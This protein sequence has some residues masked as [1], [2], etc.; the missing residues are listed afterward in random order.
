MCHDC[1]RAKK[2]EKLPVVNI[3]PAVND[4][5]PRNNNSRQGCASVTGNYY[6]NCVCMRKL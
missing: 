4:R 6:V 2:L 1:P 5:P 3:Y